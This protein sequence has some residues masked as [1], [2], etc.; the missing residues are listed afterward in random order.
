MKVDYTFDFRGSITS[1]TL[2]KLSQKF[3]EM[4][5]NQVI[6]IQGSDPESQQ[7]LFKVLPASSYELISIDA[8]DKK[9]SEEYYRILIKKKNVKH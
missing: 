4:A 6:E 9:K 7:D 2:L 3:M 1:I 8:T 5:P